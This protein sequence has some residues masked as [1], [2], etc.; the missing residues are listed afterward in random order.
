MNICTIV[1]INSN[2]E[3]KIRF[4]SESNVIIY[5]IFGI[6]FCVCQVPFLGSEAVLCLPVL[7]VA[8]ALS[9]IHI[10]FKRAAEKQFR[11]IA[12]NGNVT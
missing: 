8:F 6:S 9:L 2:A 5:F 11:I 7:G 10:F 3:C 4:V 12:E 1:P